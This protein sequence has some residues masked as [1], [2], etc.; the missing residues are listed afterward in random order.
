[1]KTI[2]V[3]GGAGFI[4]SNFVRLLVQHTQYK[5]VILDK[6][7]YAGNRSTIENLLGDQCIFVQGDIADIKVV[8]GLFATHHFAYVINFAA[9]SHVDRSISD[10]QVFIRSNILGVQVLLEASRKFGVEKYLQVSTD[11]VYGSLGPTGLFTED[12][13]LDPSSPYS[14]S[15]TSA[16]LLVQAWHRT[17]GLPVNTTRC[18]NNYGPYQ[19]P[20]KLIP[21]MIAKAQANQRLPVYGDGSNIRDWIHVTDHCTALLAVLERGISGRVYNIGGNSERNNLQVVQTILDQL[22][23]SHDLIQFVKDRLGHDWRYAIDNTR[24]QEELG[25]TPVYTFETGLQSTIEWYMTN[26]AWWKTLV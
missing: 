26:E 14:A 1:M 2:L 10:P 24:V 17:Y 4:G 9:E 5:I 11:E 6:L 15:K 3:T 8:E 22:G 25:W 19:Y 16:D 7:T 23:K 12:S 18:S 20:E 13:P 21:L